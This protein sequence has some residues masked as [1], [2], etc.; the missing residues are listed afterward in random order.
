MNKS[1][2]FILTTASLLVFSSTVHAQYY[3]YQQL[4]SNG[5]TYY[6]NGVTYY[7]AFSGDGAPYH[8]N[9]VTTDGN[10]QYSQLQ[11]S[12]LDTTYIDITPTDQPSESSLDSTCYVNIKPTE[13]LDMT[14]FETQIKKII[15]DNS[16]PPSNNEIKI[17]S[18][19]YAKQ[20]QRWTIYSAIQ[21]ILAKKNLLMPIT[22]QK[23]P[24]DAGITSVAISSGGKFVVLGF[25]GSRIKVMNLESKKSIYLDNNGK[26]AV[27]ASAISSD[28]RYV[29][30]AFVM[31]NTAMLYDMKEKEWKELAGHTKPIVSVS[32]SPDDTTVFTL[33]TDQT[34]RAWDIATGKCT[35]TTQG[36]YA[37]YALNSGAISATGKFCAS[38]HQDNSVNSTN[39]DIFNLFSGTQENISL[40]KEATSSAIS[41]HGNFIIIGNKSG[42]SQL[43][44]THYKKWSTL[45]RHSNRVSA[46]TFSPDEKF[47]ITGSYDKTAVICDVTWYDNLSFEHLILF[48]KVINS[49]RDGKKLTLGEWKNVFKTFPEHIKALLKNYVK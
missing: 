21:N 14:D 48:I 41:A 10:T 26:D 4:Q 49:K 46:A 15:N 25:F 24:T 33:S 16:L 20:Q 18:A 30:I 29:A 44:N 43:Y 17:L 42:K 36:N 35:K 11:E 2:Y 47:L 32:I 8:S 13:F 45:T 9:T 5:G 39:I 6:N 19:A 37:I 27:Q 40:N 38:I 34:V 31:N 1:H 28:G 7:G 3:Q 23:I 12:P 22:M